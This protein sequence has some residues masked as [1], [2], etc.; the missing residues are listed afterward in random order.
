M[1]TKPVLPRIP[2]G[3]SRL[4]RRI[5]TL[6][7]GRKIATLGAFAKKGLRKYRTV[8]KKKLQ[9]LTHLSIIALDIKGRKFR[10]GRLN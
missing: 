8:K 4:K 5:N 9:E 6:L 2:E 10:S 1:A 7:L 3:Y